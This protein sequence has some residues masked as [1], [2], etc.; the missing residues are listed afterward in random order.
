MRP[1]RVGALVRDAA[2]GRWRRRALRWFGRCAAVR[3]DTTR[4]SHPRG[5][6]HARAH[7][8]RCTGRYAPHAD[9]ATQPVCAATQTSA[10]DDVL[11]RFH[12][13][14]HDPIAK[15]VLDRLVTELWARHEAV[16]DMLRRLD[17]SGSGCLS[18]SDLRMGL[19][20]MHLKLT[21]NE[22]DSVIRLFDKDGSG[23]VDYV[24]FYHV[25][26]K[27]QAEKRH[28]LRKTC[29]RCITAMRW[30]GSAM[31]RSSSETPRSTP[32]YRAHAC[33]RRSSG[34]APGR[35]QR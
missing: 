19:Q 2:L 35:K 18:K 15:E 20:S 4:N 12:D 13:E 31:P 3:L 6:H 24:N 21:S 9:V 25:L 7:H 23:M 34:V 32:S 1:S 10:D 14:M 16:H 30:T 29:R 27:Y 17:K 5:I 8:P 11:R 33:A 22:L 28:R 26:T